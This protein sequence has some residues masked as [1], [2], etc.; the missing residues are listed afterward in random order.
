MRIAAMRR[1]GL[2]AQLMAIN[3]IWRMGGL[4]QPPPSEGVIS[5]SAG[6]G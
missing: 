3:L 1:Y 5:R 4:P 6:G 2:A